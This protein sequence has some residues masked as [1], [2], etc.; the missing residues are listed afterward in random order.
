MP[1][2]D[3][4]KTLPRIVG[5][6]F[7]ALGIV[8]F[9]SGSDVFGFGVNSFQNILHFLTGLMGLWAGYAS[10]RNYAVNYNKWIGLTYVVVGLIGFVSSILNAN[11]ASNLL[12]LFLGVLLTSVAFGVQS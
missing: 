12:H 11:L 10:G 2:T 8:G 4:Q 9:F 5:I 3:I 6:V 1:M 7:S